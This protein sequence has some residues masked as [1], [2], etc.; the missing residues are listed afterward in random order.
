MTNEI[1]LLKK[2]PI[3][4]EEVKSDALKCK[5]CAHWFSVK[6]VLRRYPGLPLLILFLLVYYVFFE[7]II[8]QDLA[9]NIK[10]FDPKGSGVI[11]EKHELMQKHPI[12]NII[13]K[14]ANT[15]SDSWSGIRVDAILYDKNGKT[16]DIL[17][18]YISGRLSPGETRDFA[19]KSS[20]CQKNTEPV[21]FHSYKIVVQN[22]LSE[23]Y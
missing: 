11:V 20:S 9:L 22:A 7:V 15:G 14:I 12:I 6:S 21:A 8:K 10:Q 1:N 16:I 19:I 5:Y 4:A 17:Q 2:C 23:V 3:C 18:G 13:G